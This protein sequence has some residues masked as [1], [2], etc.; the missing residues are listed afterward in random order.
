MQS[1]EER[2]KNHYVF[3]KRIDKDATRGKQEHDEKSSISWKQEERE[4]VD[5]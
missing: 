4:T 1:L 2:S 3:K 5:E